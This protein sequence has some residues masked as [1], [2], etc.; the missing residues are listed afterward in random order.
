MKTLTEDEGKLSKEYKEITDKLKSKEFR[1]RF[2]PMQDENGIYD[3]GEPDEFLI[4]NEMINDGIV[5]KEN[6][7][8]VINQAMKDTLYKFVAFLTD[9]GEF[10]NKYWERLGLKDTITAKQRDENEQQESTPKNS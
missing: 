10:K 5:F 3:F 6:D 7:K 2:K 1:R 4:I 9:K 8:L